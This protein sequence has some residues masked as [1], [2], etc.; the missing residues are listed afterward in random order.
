MRQSPA[1]VAHELE[2]LAGLVVAGAARAAAHVVAAA[3]LVGAPLSPG[4]ANSEEER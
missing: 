4:M 2:A 3:A 1:S